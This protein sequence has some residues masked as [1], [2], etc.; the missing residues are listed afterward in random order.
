MTTDDA[1]PP[2]PPTLYDWAGG[3]P[4]FERLTARFYDRVRDDATLAPVFAHMSAEHPRHV[5]RFLAEVFRGPAEYTASRGGHATML[6]HHLGK[7]LTREQ[8]ARWVALLIECADELALPDDP[9]FRSAFVAYIEWGSRLA[10]LN[11]QDGVQPVLDPPMPSW[12]WGEVGGPYT[13]P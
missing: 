3:M 1:P 6:A 12:G 11:S 4:A 2:A 7:R 9:E 8:R 10:L 5:A 13:G